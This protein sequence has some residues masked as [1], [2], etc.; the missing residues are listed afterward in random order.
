M[1]KHVENPRAKLRQDRRQERCD[2][3]VVSEDGTHLFTLF[4]RQSTMLSESFSAG[5]R[6]HAKS[7]EEIILVRYNG[8][9][10][11]HENDLE[12]DKISYAT[13]IH[14][15]TE[16]YA[17]MNKKVDAYAESS[18]R[19]GTLNGALHCLVKD[20]NIM[21]LSTEPEEPQLF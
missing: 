14:R 7:G 20:C 6:W 10:H 17:A 2:Y 19:Y 12:G 16:R 4:T 8:G 13:H 18:P 3:R 15:A 1:A 11:E 5:L 21:G 9:S